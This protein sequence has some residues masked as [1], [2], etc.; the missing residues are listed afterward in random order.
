M[1]QSVVMDIEDGKTSLDVDDSVT[2]RCTVHEPDKLESDWELNWHK[3]NRH[4]ERSKLTNGDELSWWV[5]EV[6]PGHFTPRSTY[7]NID[8]Q[9]LPVHRLII[10]GK[11]QD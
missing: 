3:M 1:G 4:G 2:F 8:G 10:M 6:S 9:M 11:Y 7:K 5:D